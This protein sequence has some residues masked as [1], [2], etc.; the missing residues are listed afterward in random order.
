MGRWG[1]G[2]I[3]AVVVLVALLAGLGVGATVQHLRS[4]KTVV[5]PT[6][7]TQSW[8]KA[9]VREGQ[10]V[11]LAWGDRAG[12]DPSTAPAELRFDAARAVA[13]LDALYALDVF[14]LGVVDADGAIARHKIVVVVDGTWSD[15]PGAPTEVVVVPTVG[16]LSQPERGVTGSVTEGVGLLRVDVA[17]LTARGHRSATSPATADPAVAGGSEFDPSWELARGFAEVVQGFASLDAPGRGF[18]SDDAATFWSASAAY[19][20][21][22][23]AP[24]GIGD[25]ADLVRSPQLHWASPR[26]GDGGWLL[27]QYLAERDGER[28]LGSMW[29]EAQEGEDPLSTYKRLTGLTQ[30]DLNRRIAE[31]ALRTVTWDFTDRSA[32]AAAVDALDPVLLADRTTPVETVEGDPGHYRVLDGFAPSDYGF[33][34]VRLQPDAGVRDLHLRLR[35]H[36][37]AADAG[38]SFGFVVLRNG[39]PRYSPVTESLDQEVQL[40]LRSGEQE[41]YLVVVGTPTQNHAHGS[42]AGFGEVARYPYEFRLSGA[43][44]VEDAARAVTPG[45]H[46]HANGGGWV[47]DTATVDPTAFVGPD[48]V[49]RGDAQVLGTARIEGRAWVEAGAVVEGSAVVRD[50]ALVRSTARLGGTV[51][52]AGDAVVSFTCASGTYTT[53]DP[54]RWCDGRTSLADVNATSVPFSAA[55]LVLSNAPEPTATPTPDPTPT[56][57]PTPTPSRTPPAPTPEPTKAPSPTEGGVEPPEPMPASACTAVYT[58]TNHWTSE[59]QNWFQGQVVVTAGSTGVEGWAVTWALPA[60]EQITTV[61]NARL[62]TSGSQVTAENMSYNGSLRDGDSAT[63]GFQGTAPGDAGLQVPPVSCTR[64][65]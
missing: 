33:T 41:V 39:V 16:G 12:P 35:G 27:L 38:L 13:Q 5:V 9:H 48:A 23:A 62:G 21:T 10:D 61:W 14:D 32:I 58:V 15:G 11:V 54:A 52:V 51:L 7:W 22:V 46:R 45:G 18:A 63:F 40:T 26:L 29:R 17:A 24:G 37:D 64:T 42:T 3:V 57:T 30:A 1:R 2:G 49:V 6:A 60:G 53:F 59:G 56:P 43:R 44:V 55:D 25:P 50:V 19:L 8:K 47:D 31:Y 36:T 4:D 34:I 28:L 20:A 65:R